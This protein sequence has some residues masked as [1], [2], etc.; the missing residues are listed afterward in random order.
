MF[1]SLPIAEKSELPYL[2]L[3]DVGEEPLHKEVLVDMVRP[4]VGNFPILYGPKG[5]F[6]Y[7]SMLS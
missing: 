3:D 1:E 6:I 4:E 5:G 7:L 2:Q